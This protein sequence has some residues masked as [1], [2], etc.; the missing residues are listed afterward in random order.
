MKGFTG[1]SGEWRVGVGLEG[2]IGAGE[3]W[4]RQKF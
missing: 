3:K 2:R 4:R 1:A